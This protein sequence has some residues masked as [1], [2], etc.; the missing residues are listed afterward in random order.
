MCNLFAASLKKPEKASFFLPYFEELLKTASI[1]KDGWGVGFFENNKF[2]VLKEPSP[3]TESA[4]FPRIKNK[5]K[6]SI[7]LLHLRE[8]SGWSIADIKNTHPFVKKL[9]KKSWIFMHNGNIPRKNLEMLPKTKYEAFG[10][11]DSERIFC[12][13]LEFLDVKKKEKTDAE[14]HRHLMDVAL[15]GSVNVIFSNGKKLFVFRGDKKRTLF[16]HASKKGIVFSRF[17][18]CTDSWKVIKVGSLI[19]SKKGKITKI[20]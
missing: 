5:I 9:K 15:L 12:S 18:I 6:T 16:Y 1:N 10:D 19:V 8:K 2:V 13:I 4:I 14:I 11:T 17:K 3:I 20:L 7:I